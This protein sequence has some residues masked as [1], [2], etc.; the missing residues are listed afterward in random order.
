[1]NEPKERFDRLRRSQFRVDIL[2]WLIDAAVAED[3][4]VRVLLDQKIWATMT[5]CGLVKSNFDD[6]LRHRFCETGLNYEEYSA[7]IE[8]RLM[9]ISK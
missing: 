2:D 9:E 3:Q 6:D 7:L 4:S 5:G 8:A 1:M